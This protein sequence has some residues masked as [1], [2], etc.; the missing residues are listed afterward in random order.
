MGERVAQTAA[1]APARRQEVM[2]RRDG[3][4]IVCRASTDTAEHRTRC[5]SGGLHDL[6]A[7]KAPW[8]RPTLLTYRHEGVYDCCSD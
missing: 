7:A 1:A 5:W 8:V 3:A 4:T 6:T 2:Q